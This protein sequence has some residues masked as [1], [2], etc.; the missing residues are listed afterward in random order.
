MQFLNN[1]S[2]AKKFF[3]APIITILFMV[4]TNLT[5]VSRLNTMEENLAYIHDISLQKRILAQKMI[6]HIRSI[7]LQNNAMINFKAFMDVNL[8][9]MDERKNALFSEQAALEKGLKTLKDGFSLSDEEAKLLKQARGFHKE[10]VEAYSAVQDMLE[11]DP[12]TAFVY[13]PPVRLAYDQYI[14]TITKLNDLQGTLIKKAYDNSIENAEAA[15]KETYSLL[16]LALLVASIVT[17]ILGALLSRPM[18]RLTKIMK[19]LADND[20]SVK[21]LYR[22]RKDEIGAMAETVQVFKDNAEG[23]RRLEQAQKEQE[24]HAQDEKK[25]SM[26]ALADDFEQSIK[27]VVNMVRQSSEEVHRSAENLTTLSQQ[28]ANQTN[29]VS[30]VTAQSSENVASVAT[31]A[32]EL[33]SSIQE[34]SGQVAKST[35]IASEAV[36]QAQK[37]NDMVQGLSEATTKIGDVIEMITDIANQT[38]L[39]ALNATIEAARAGE[40]GKGFAVVASEVKSLASQTAKATEEIAEQITNVQDATK[41]AVDTIQ[42]VTKTIDEISEISSTISAAVEEQ[43]ASTQGITQNIQETARGT[44]E[45]SANVGQVNQAMADAEG[46]AD[47]V[48]EISNTLVEEAGNLDR[49]VQSFIEKIRR[50][51]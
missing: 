6:D 44:Q 10:Y 51:A 3:L 40:A 33:S 12:A 26:R 18:G 4:A 5:A 45:V 38:N 37:A 30:Q 24:K 48:L 14:S 20:L 39:L 36:I 28:V 50:S 15:K 17:W 16:A 41:T 7:Q 8:E 32:E 2:V 46:A 29:E 11:I 49:D 25:R 35:Q 43:G 1:L 23:M 27:S 13:M 34:I 21:V 19:R 31:A 42:A 22:G 9:E 47:Q